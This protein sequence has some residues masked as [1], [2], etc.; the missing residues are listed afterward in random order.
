MVM[1]QLCWIFVCVCLLPLVAEGKGLQAMVDRTQTDLET[2]IQLTVSIP[3]DKGRVD[4]GAISDFKVIS[5]G[6]SSRMQIINGQMSQEKTFN[7]TLVPLRV[8]RLK[9]PALAVFVDDDTFYTDAIDILVTRTQSAPK[10]ANDFFVTATLSNPHPYVGQ[11]IVYT[12][13]LRY[14]VQIAN[15][16]Y[17]SPSFEGFTAKQIGEQ[18]TS[19][20]VVNGRQYQVVTLSYLLVPLKSGSFEISPA[21]LRCDKVVAV[22]NRS[23]DP[24]DS[25]FNDSLFGRKRLEPKILRT[26]AIPVTVSALPPYT[27]ENP[28]SGLVGQFD[29]K[30]DLE[31]EKAAVGASV[32]LTVTLEGRGNIQD[33]DMPDLDLPTVFKQYQ[34]QPESDVT[35]GPNGYQ[36]KKVFR[37]ALVPV[38]PGCY[39]VAVTPVTYFDP[40]QKKY[41]TLTTPPL[42]LLVHDTGTGPASPDVY[43]ASPEDNGTP[44]LFKKQVEFKGRDILPLKTELDALE[45]PHK[46]SMVLFLGGLVTP[47]VLFLIAVSALNLFQKNDRPAAVMAQKSKQELDAAIKSHENDGIDYLSNLYR[48]L[49]Y[50]ALSKS[51]IAGETLT[52]DEFASLLNKQGVPDKITTQAAN[53]LSQIEQTRFGGGALTGSAKNELVEKTKKI[54][55]TIVR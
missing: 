51:G 32:T 21:L 30:A 24:F 22:A 43:S 44:Q 36:G 12:F 16:N 5:R 2:P 37:T 29:F 14:S 55:K 8:G 52:P 42:A 53:L 3:D 15:T 7:Y 39:K 38:A 20:M 13:E 41:R 49:V 23:R 28:F 47:A 1:K 9:I 34:D 46:V 17:E 4:T 6:S 33:A 10:G 31:E 18:K 40:A 35:L 54:V 27:G 25:F 45:I 19:Q 26:D 48:A 50:A 11:Q